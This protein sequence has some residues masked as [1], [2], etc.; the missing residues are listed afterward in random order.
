MSGKHMVSSST[1]KLPHFISFWCFSVLG[2]LVTA[3][4]LKTNQIMFQCKQAKSTSFDHIEDLM[5]GQVD[6]SHLSYLV[7]ITLKILKA[8]LTYCIFHSIAR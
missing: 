6:V 2:V 3:L 8:Q 5:F 7:E 1:H 4:T